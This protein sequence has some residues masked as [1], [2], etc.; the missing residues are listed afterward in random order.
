MVLLCIL[1]L[2]IGVCA[3]LLSRLYDSRRPTRS[4]RRRVRNPDVRTDDLLPDTSS[5]APV[6]YK[7]RTY[8]CSKTELRF[9]YALIQAFPDLTIMSKV[10][11]ADIITPAAHPKTSSFHS[12]FNSIRSKHVDFVACA[13]NLKILFVI[14]LD[15]SSHRRPDR[16]SRDTFVNDILTKAGISIFRFSCSQQYSLDVIRQRIR[17]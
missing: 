17:Y 10:R 1:F 3:P 7:S 16:I 12:A 6:A 14:E 9:Y 4:I 11:L 13:S 8:L 15:D 5:P 2:I